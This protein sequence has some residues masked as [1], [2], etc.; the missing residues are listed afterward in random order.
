MYFP[1]HLFWF[2]PLGGKKNLTGPVSRYRAL[3]CP[4]TS[5]HCALAHSTAGRC[6]HLQHCCLISKGSQAY[7]VW[8]KQGFAH[9]CAVFSAVSVPSVV[10][11]DHDLCKSLP[12]LLDTISYCRHPNPIS[13]MS[14]AV[15][16]CAL[17]PVCWPA[18]VG[19][20]HEHFME[21]R[22]FDHFRQDSLS[23]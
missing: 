22:R 5:L 11:L 3:L 17:L 16:E 13:Q 21:G 8:A 12:R 20:E 14:L 10:H 15:W 18:D 2:M 23:A 19:C 4:V 7:I 9:C 6:R 1:L